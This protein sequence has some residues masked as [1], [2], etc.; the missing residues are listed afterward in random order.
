MSTSEKPTAINKRDHHLVLFTKAMTLVFARLTGPDVYNDRSLAILLEVMRRF[1]ADESMDLSR[2]SQD[3]RSQFADKE[4]RQQ[5]WRNLREMYLGVQFNR[6]TVRQFGPFLHDEQ[7]A[8]RLLVGA[9]GKRRVDTVLMASKDYLLG[10]CNATGEFAT[11]METLERIEEILRR[12]FGFHFGMTEDQILML[13]E[14]KA[15]LCNRHIA[16]IDLID[17]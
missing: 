6:F 4:K 2:V 14:S 17:L 1:A 13:C 5:I 8:Q 7:V 16:T 15:K 12:K 11:D 9:F 10:E 3:I